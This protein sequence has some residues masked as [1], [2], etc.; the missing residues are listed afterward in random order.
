MAT[1]IVKS[2]ISRKGLY[3]RRPLRSV[4]RAATPLKGW[5]PHPRKEFIMFVKVGKMPGTVQEVAL[6]N[7]AKVKDAIAA[8]GITLG[9]SDEIRMG[10]TVVNGDATVREGAVILLTAKIKGN[11]PILVKVGKMPGTV[12]ELAVEAGTKVAEVIRMAGVTL[13][14]SDEIRMSGTVVSGDNIVTTAGAVILITAK[15]KGNR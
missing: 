10:G 4:A 13:G 6:E 1:A 12:T 2:D 15:I 11:A 8:A 7:G 14:A 3:I 5:Q 9:A